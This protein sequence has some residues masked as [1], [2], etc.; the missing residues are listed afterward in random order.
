M[1]G[2]EGAQKIEFVTLLRNQ[3]IGAIG[4][5]IFDFSKPPC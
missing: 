5:M 4:E 3:A 1:A 2:V